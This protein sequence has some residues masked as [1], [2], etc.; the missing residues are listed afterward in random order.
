MENIFDHNPTPAEL[1]MLLGTVQ[2]R[3]EYERIKLDEVSRR[4]MIANLY[5]LRK[6]ESKAA[7]IAAELPAAVRLELFGWDIISPAP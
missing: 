2:T 5:M 7:E 6:D 4:A 3:A 1:Q